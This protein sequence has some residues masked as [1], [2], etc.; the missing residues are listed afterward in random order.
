METLDAA[1]V[2][3]GYGFAFGSMAIILWWHCEDDDHDRDL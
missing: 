3:W 2:G 1:M